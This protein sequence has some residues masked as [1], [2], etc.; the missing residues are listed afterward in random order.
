MCNCLNVACEKVLQHFQAKHGEAAIV[1]N[2]TCQNQDLVINKGSM[3]LRTY[4]TIAVDY[5]PRKKDGT[6]GK[7]KKLSMPV[8]HAYCPN[9]GLPFDESE[10]KPANDLTSGQ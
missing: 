7:Q 5:T 1:A 4:N 3:T 6:L 8:L 10:I 2:P 9:C